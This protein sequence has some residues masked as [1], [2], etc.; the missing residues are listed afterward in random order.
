M[1]KSGPLLL[2]C[3]L[4]LVA[5]NCAELRHRGKAAEARRCY[6]ALA[7]SGN[8]YQRAEGLWGLG[9][10]QDANNA[11]REAVA[12]DP[13][14]AMYKVRWGRMLLERFNKADA[15]GLFTEALEAQPSN[16]GALLGLALVAA[17]GFENKAVDMARKALASDPKLVEAQEL[18][19]RLALEDGGMKRAAGEADKAIA[20]SGEAFDAM[21]V[22]ASIDWLNAPALTLESPWMDRIAKINPAYGKAWAAAGRFFVLNRRY[23]EGIRLYRKAVEVSP[24]LWSAHSELGVNLMRLGEDDEA[25]RE[26]E[27]CYTNGYRDYATVNTLRLLDSYRNFTFFR[28]GGVVLK[29]DKKEAEALRPYFEAEIRRAMKVYEKKYGVRLKEPVQVEVYPNHEDFAV[30][31]LGMPGLGALGVSFGRVVAMDSPSSRARGSFHWA[32]TLWHELSHVYVLTA[33]EHRVPRWFT[34]G[35]AVHE[36]TA[37]SP[38]WGD[39]LSADAILAIQ[40]KKLLPLAQLDRGFVRPT[41]PSQVVVSYFQAGKLCDYISKT[42]GEEKLVA[43]IRAFAERKTTPETIQSVLNMS[44][45]ELDRRFFAWLDANTKKTVDGFEDWRNRMRA[46]AE[47]AKAGRNDEVIRDGPALRDLYP[48]YVE[49]GS[50]YELIAEACEKKGDAAG[51]RAELERYSKAGGRDPAAIKKL[52]TL[53]EKEGKG[54]EAA[55]AL[56]RLIY[57]DP[58][59]EE[60]HRRLGDLWMAQGNAAGAIGEY[61]AV[62]ALRP[63]DVAAS[64]FNLARAYRAAARANEA[65]EQLLMALEAAPGFRPAQKMLLELNQ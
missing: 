30:R 21:A 20:M 23:R 13:K 35:L 25:R 9:E 52:A 4:P 60:L 5:Q 14:N 22:R 47:A 8:P 36:E 26:L 58:L 41:Y 39:R 32:S 43:M 24:D 15:A 38:D 57:I 6:A 56:G 3:A 64:H 50:A 40:Q 45:E 31:T 49:D 18:L 11:F 7:Q 37:T 19:A 61:K 55:A 48:E 2:L 46:L 62:I 17:D 65:K 54:K 59:D 44:P 63:L 29:L 27:L 16:A 53:L 10:F 51:A 42:W 1:M 12:A 34:E 28:E 33:T